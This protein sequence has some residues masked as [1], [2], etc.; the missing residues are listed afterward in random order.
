MLMMMM[1]R[2]SRSSLCLRHRPRRQWPAPCQTCSATKWPDQTVVVRASSLLTPRGGGRRA[3][4]FTLTTTC[5]ARAHS[6]ILDTIGRGAGV[7]ERTVQHMR[8]RA[9]LGAATRIFRVLHH[10][11]RPP[12][13]HLL[14]HRSGAASGCLDDCLR[15]ATHPAGEACAHLT[16]PML[17]V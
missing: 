9:D 6:L 10:L 7:Y 2:L 8:Q 4:V 3:V 1:S 16:R 11:Y 12:R 13:G 14:P 5:R 17:S 15:C